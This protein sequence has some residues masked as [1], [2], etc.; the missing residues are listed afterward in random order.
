L[1]ALELFGVDNNIINVTNSQLSSSQSNSQNTKLPFKFS[2]QDN[3]SNLSQTQ[4]HQIQLPQIKQ[5]YVINKN[6][7]QNYKKGHLLLT[8]K[9]FEEKIKELKELEKSIDDTKKNIDNI[10]KN[11]DDI[12]KNIIKLKFIDKIF[13]KCYPDS[14]TKDSNKLHTDQKCK[15]F[16]LIKE[17]LITEILNKFIFNLQK[18][19]K[20]DKIMIKFENLLKS[21]KDETINKFENLLKSKE[22]TKEL[23]KKLTEELNKDKDLKTELTE[24]VDKKYENLFHSL[25]T[26]VNK[27]KEQK[28]KY[29][30]YLYDKVKYDKVKQKKNF[31]KQ[32]DKVEYDESM[33]DILKEILKE[34]GITNEELKKGKKLI[35]ESNIDF[36][37]FGIVEEKEEEKEEEKRV[38]PNL[39]I[40]NLMK[41]KEQDQEK[42][43][44]EETEDF[45]DLSQI[46]IDS[47]QQQNKKQDQQIKK[48]N[49]FFSLLDSV[50]KDKTDKTGKEI[51]LK[52]LN[53]SQQRQQGEQ[54]QQ[55]ESKSKFL[56]L[57]DEASDELRKENEKIN[58][59]DH[60][61]NFFDIFNDS[62][63]ISEGQ[64]ECGEE[65]SILYLSALNLNDI[66]I[67]I[68]NT[69]EWNEKTGKLQ[70]EIP[71][72]TSNSGQSTQ[73]ESGD[74]FKRKLTIDT[75]ATSDS[76]PQV[77]E[78]Y[79]DGFKE[80]K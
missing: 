4:L 21:K 46:I 55:F 19:K 75:T 35:D 72:S 50:Y 6:D 37:V 73:V 74:C 11:I 57:L 66:N 62:F 67:S 22:L 25:H 52:I 14:K 58:K 63:S 79:N 45:I 15:N 23:T 17:D 78:L 51:I 8:K 65:R 2:L 38:T 9:D 71:V 31:L 41:K 48:E 49:K 69:Q 44:V 30:N 61:I 20:K 24:F 10:K 80:F 34:M 64:I 53:D 42:K 29:L 77:T 56:K 28:E 70:I 26:D 7:I 18:N 76:S 13:D 12:K 27:D 5:E 68:L 33:N 43:K 16:N 54:G 32:M 39:V 47:T 40:K 3:K 1:K 59:H 36:D 60:E